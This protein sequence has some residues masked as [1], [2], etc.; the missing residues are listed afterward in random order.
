MAPS[1][2]SIDAMSPA[3]SGTV[4]VFTKQNLFVK[5][6]HMAFF[7][8]HPLILSPDIIWQT[9][10]QGL[11]NHVDQNAEELRSK[12]VSHEGKKNCY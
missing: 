2:G 8:H 6:V 9:I 10:A 1:G 4:E 12:F 7:G 11:A 3:P 5:S